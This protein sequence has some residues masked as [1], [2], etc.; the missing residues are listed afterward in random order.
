[1]ASLSSGLVV[2]GGELQE[3]ED[4]RGGRRKLERQIGALVPVLL[5]LFLKALMKADSR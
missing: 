3:K 4:K 2:A 5:D 1:M